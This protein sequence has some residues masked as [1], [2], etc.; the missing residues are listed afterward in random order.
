MSEINNSC[1]GAQMLP[2]SLFLGGAGGKQRLHT[3]R[4]R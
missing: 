2:L 1:L 3:A 4:T